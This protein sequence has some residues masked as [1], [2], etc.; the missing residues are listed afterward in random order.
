MKKLLI[1]GLATVTAIWLLVLPGLVGGY[2]RGQVPEWIEAWPEAET[3]QFTPGWFRSQLDW[4][5][6]DG[7]NIDLQARHLPVLKPGLI[8]LRG[9]VGSPMT[10]SPIRLDG[11][12]GLTGGWH[13]QLDAE[14]LSAEA[15]GGL[16]GR[17]L[18]LNLAQAPG[19][20]LT[21]IFQADSLGHDSSSA[22]LPGL[23]DVRILARSQNGPDGEL[24]LGLDL[25]LVAETLGPARLTLNAAPVPAD[26]LSEL[27]DGLAQLA[28]S[29]ADSFAESMALLTVAGAWQQM[30]AAGMVIRLENL[31][32]GSST[33]LSGTWPAG[34]NQPRLDG[35]GQTSEL[36][37]WYRT[38]AYRLGGRAPELAELEARAWLD[39]LV[40][41]GW[42]RLD[43]NTFR[44]QAPGH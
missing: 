9:Q 23:E 7:V 42:L 38:L 17:A 1:I 40:D 16:H 8:R 44:V 13:L 11:Q 36:M 15:T 22:D 3:T 30:A 39:T 18:G 12:V 32:L 31:S 33:A 28:G 19:Q 27:M 43:G 29:S 20:P 26:A 41:A 34:H 10:T 2:L 6:D 14:A 35:T 5:S 4:A 25:N 37:A 24:V 21:A